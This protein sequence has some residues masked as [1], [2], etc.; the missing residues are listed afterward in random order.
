MPPAP[1]ASQNKN[2]TGD[3]PRRFDSTGMF[4]W[5]PARSLDDAIMVSTCVIEIIGLVGKTGCV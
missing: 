4:H 3:E 2:N 5:C 1:W